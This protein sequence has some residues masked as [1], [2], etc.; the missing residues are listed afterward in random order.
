MKG[1]EA[2]T[3]GD[4]SYRIEP[5]HR[6]E[7]FNQYDEIIDGINKMAK[8]LESSETMKKDFYLSSAVNP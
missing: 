7:L 5:F 2:I 6:F 8:E 4:F 1:V 3:T